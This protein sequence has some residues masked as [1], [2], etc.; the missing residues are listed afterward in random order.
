MAT[1]IK[2]TAISNFKSRA[3]ANYKWMIVLGG[4]YSVSAFEDNTRI[5]RNGSLDT[6]LNRQEVSTRTYSTGDV[7][8]T[9]VGKGF[10]FVG[11]L[12]GKTGICY[13]WEGTLFAHRV[14]RFTPTFFYTATRGPA[15]V[16]IT[17][18]TVG[19]VVVNADVVQK[20]E[21]KTYQSS[22]TDDQYIITSDKPIAVYV[23][24]QESTTG[25]ADSLPLY[26]ASTEFFGTFSNGGHIINCASSTNNILVRSSTGD[27]TTVTLNQLGGISGE[28]SGFSAGGSFFG[29]ACKVISE[30]P[31]FC[32][33]Q[34][35]GDG[36][37][38]TPFVSREAFG[39]E[40]VIPEDE[41]EWVKLV[42]DVPATYEVF[43]SAN[44]YLGGGSLAG[45]FFDSARTIGATYPGEKVGGIFQVR[46]GSATEGASNL[47]RQKNLI[48]TSA[49]VYGVF[50]SEDDD[51]T[52]L[53]A[54]VK[55]N[56]SIHINPKIITEGLI[57]NLDAGNTKS[58]PGSGTTWTDLSKENNHATLSNFTVGSLNGGTLTAD[59]AN[60]VATINAAASLQPASITI[61]VMCKPIYNNQN[62]ANVISYPP[63]D[64]AHQSPY[65]IYAIYLK[66]YGGD[67]T[68]RPI[69]TRI[70]GTAH[71]S[72]NGFYDFGVWNHMVLTFHNQSIKYYRDGVLKGTDTNSAATINYSGYENQNV[73]I[74]QNPSGSED[75]EGEYSN[76]K[77]YNRALT[78]A[79][80]AQ[81]FNAIRGR[82]GL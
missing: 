27:K 54:R 60:S 9:D 74:G 59:G 35:D 42:S 78:D 65:M 75:F 79:E 58:Y 13:G 39:T 25:G 26:P 82:F 81:N 44:V 51:E 4:N 55:N 5:F 2:P 8:S 72:P 47:T 18:E 71:D 38:M 20:D 61:E 49:P 29:E 21:L 17:R 7:I 41:N 15:T 6:T 48:R 63:N 56:S 69:H 70:G 23:D 52:V 57:L 45:S 19:T 28:P 46:I 1:V 36:G 73:F 77:L 24:D 67:I 22:D 66:H 68:S 64:D 80:V 62:F 43:D 30:K 33:S 11:Q 16:T 10:S 37:E 31:I 14:D 50:E 34:A 53:F 3:T 76:I 32:E 12:G 40:F